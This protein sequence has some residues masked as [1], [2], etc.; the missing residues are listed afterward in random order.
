MNSVVQH[1]KVQRQLE[2]GL[3]QG[4]L[5]NIASM[6]VKRKR[7]TTHCKAF[8]IF[9][10]SGS[11]GPPNISDPNHPFTSF[12]HAQLAFPLVIDLTYE[13]LASHGQLMLSHWPTT[14]RAFT[15]VPLCPVQHIRYSCNKDYITC[16]KYRTVVCIRIFHLPV[17]CNISCC[18][19]LPSCANLCN[20]PFVVRKYGLEAIDVVEHLAH[21]RQIR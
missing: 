17:F 10:S 14:L 6:R 11:S 8:R 13:A 4:Q 21:T 2:T 9:F 16:S 20:I 12:H 3:D 19:R 18:H 5:Y 15:F 7:I 1:Q